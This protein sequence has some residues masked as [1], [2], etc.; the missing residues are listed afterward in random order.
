MVMTEIDLY[1]ILFLFLLIV[2]D[3][4][5]IVLHISTIMYIDFID[6]HFHFSYMTWFL[7]IY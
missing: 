7:L 1:P 5:S 3:L 6:I 2:F 4:V